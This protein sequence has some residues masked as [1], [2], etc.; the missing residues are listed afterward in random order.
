MWTVE[1][2]VHTGWAEPNPCGWARF[3]PAN[4]FEP[5]PAHFQKKLKEKKNIVQY[6]WFLHFFY[7]VLFNLDLF[8]CHTNPVLK[9]PVFMKNFQKYKKKLKKRKFFVCIWPSV[10]K[11]KNHIVFF[12][13]KTKTMF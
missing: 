7:Y 10:S 1:G 13:H 8:F 4:A 12:I 6:L 11:L 2:T 3:G 9:Y 5:G